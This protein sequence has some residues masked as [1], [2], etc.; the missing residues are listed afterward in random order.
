[1]KIK[2]IIW[3]WNGTIVNDAFL[4]V[5]IMNGLL[6]AAS[7]PQISSIDYK[8]K[9][10]FPIQSYWSLLGF[11]FT[12]ETFNKMNSEFIL[13]YKK[14]MFKPLLHPGL[15]SLFLSLK[16]RKINQFVVSASENSLLR[17]SVKHYGLSSYFRAVCGVDNLHA[18]GK[19]LVAF[20]LLVEYKL[21]KHETLW[22]GD[23]EQD[24]EIASSLDLP[25]VLVSFGHI[26]K[27]RLLKTGA[28]V[29]SSIKELKKHLGIRV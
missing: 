15:N 20:E 11:T 26:S 18:L 21:Q 12:D 1:M 16:K 6:R 27:T 13:N 4:F 19:E 23:T 7:L 10:C 17:S 24:F 9:F 5:Q 2:N 22:I 28:P 14:Q 3:D 25:V 8:N 29:V